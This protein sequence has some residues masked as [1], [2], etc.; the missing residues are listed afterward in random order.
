MSLISG[1][2][3]LFAVG[4]TIISFTSSRY[5]TTDGIDSLA[6]KKLAANGKSKPT[7]K[8]NIR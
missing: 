2:K 7:N 6:F 8:L 1:K 5:T 3:S 4:E